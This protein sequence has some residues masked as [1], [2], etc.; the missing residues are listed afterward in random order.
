MLDHPVRA[1]R[2]QTG[3]NADSA[4]RMATC[5]TLTCQN[6]IAVH[7]M[8]RRL[9]NRQRFVWTSGNALTTMVAQVGVEAQPI[10]VLLP[11]VLRTDIHAGLT[12]AIHNS[13]MDAALGMDG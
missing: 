6:Q 1:E 7:H 10:V 11:G 5:N 2:M 3:H 13:L 4:R 9:R 12:V 8:G